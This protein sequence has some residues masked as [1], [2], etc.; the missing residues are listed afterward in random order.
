VA[1]IFGSFVIPSTLASPADLTAWMGA[2]TAPALAVPLLRSA[3]TL[4]L[5]ATSASYYDA[6]PATGLPTDAQTLKV[7][8]DATCIQAAAW[9]AIKYNPLTGGVITTGVKTSKSIGTAH[10]TYADGAMAA[11]ARADAI[12]DLVPDAL[13]ML[14]LNGLLGSH[15]RMFG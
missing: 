13:R 3:T 8:N 12:R 10:I 7:M 2:T 14:E 5:N 15:V 1:G 9:D 4:V 11:Q 6:D